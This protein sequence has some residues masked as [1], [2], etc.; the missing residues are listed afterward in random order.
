MWLDTFKEKYSEQIQKI[1][2]EEQEVYDNDIINDCIDN[3]W[4]NWQD[5]DES[6]LSMMVDNYFECIELNKE[7]D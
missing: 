2:N 6:D 3:L 4:C 7:D 5:N 1:C